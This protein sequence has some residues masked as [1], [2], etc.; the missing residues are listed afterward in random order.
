MTA[1]PK[2]L[3]NGCKNERELYEHDEHGDAIGKHCAY[4][5][6]TLE[7]QREVAKSL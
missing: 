3:V 1:I 7:G 6:E 5:G 2:C 4:H